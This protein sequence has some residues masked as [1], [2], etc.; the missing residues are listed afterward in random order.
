MLT[1]MP[2]PRKRVRTRRKP[3]RAAASRARAPK[4]AR[5]ASAFTRLRNQHRAM[6]VR[7]AHF[8]AAL[9]PGPR[10]RAAP[11]PLAAYRALAR[12]LAGSFAVHVAAE[13][14]VLFPALSRELPELSLT[15]E[16]LRDD[17]AELGHMTASLQQRLAS[18]PGPERDEQLA[19]LGRDIVDL[20]RLHIRNEER[21]VLDWS[22]RV[23]PPATLRELRARLGRLLAR[24]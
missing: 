11:A 1:G 13:D 2:V 7:L 8:E 6:L 20:L 3:A 22:E 5:I 18:P 12:W 24:S 16:P 19:V 14:G 17:H 23:L 15:L 21:S 10:T 9:R 4:V